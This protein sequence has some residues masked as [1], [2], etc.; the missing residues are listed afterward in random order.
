MFGYHKARRETRRA[1]QGQ[2]QLRKEQ[3]DW[4]SKTPEREHKSLDLQ[5]NQINERVAQGKI[6]RSTARE[7]GRAD[8]ESFLNKE[9]QGMDPKTRDALQYEA[10][11]NIH[12]GHQ[13]ANRKLLGE[14][15]QRGIVGKGGVGYAQQRDLLKMANEAQGAADRDLTK[16]D[17]DLALK[18][19]AAIFAGGQGEATQSQLDNQRAID[20]IN[21]AEEKMHQRKYQDQFYKQWQRLL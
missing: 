19:Q 18:K 3:Q 8:T 5:K 21:L 17:R 15:G 14:Q 1:A 20:E 4:E 7:E 6:D 11:N 12:K 16:L 9:V 10:Y 13:S 2:N